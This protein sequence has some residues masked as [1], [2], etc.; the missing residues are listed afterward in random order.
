MKVYVISLVR[1]KYRRQRITEQMA[2]YGIEF[3]FFDAVDGKLENPLFT[4]YDYK[5]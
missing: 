4:D 2:S 5:K 1:S 3:E